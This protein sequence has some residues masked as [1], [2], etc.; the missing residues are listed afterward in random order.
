MIDELRKKVLDKYKNNEVKIQRFEYIYQIFQK[1]EEAL[2][3][4]NEIQYQYSLLQ[5]QLL[6]AEKKSKKTDNNWNKV[7]H[8]L[9]E[10]DSLIE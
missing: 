4:Y 7:K 5:K 8:L 9:H 2:K 10:F 3:E 1:K 6:E